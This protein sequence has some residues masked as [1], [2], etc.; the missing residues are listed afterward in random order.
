[1][2]Q[3]KFF[4]CVL[5]CT[6]LSASVVA[7]GLKAFKL[8]NGLS[9]FV[10]EDE[11]A[12]D[13]FG[14]V[15]VNVGA[16][17]DPEEYTGLAHYLEHMLFKGT[18][19]I[20]TLDWEKE[21]PIYVQIVAKYDELAQAVDP[22]QREAI[23]KEI[24]K[25]TIAAAQHNLSSDFSYL[26]QGIGGEN[27]NAGTSY[28]YTVYYNSFP[29]GGIYK[30][31]ELNSERLINPVFR[32]FQPELETVYEEYNR[33]Q[34]QPNSRESEFILS[35]IFPGHPY[36]RSVIGLPEHLKN[37]QLSRLDEFYRRWYVP[38]NMALILV[39][40]VKT[41]EVLP[42]IKEKFGRLESRPVPERKQYPE[43]PLKGRKEA[44]AKLSLYPQ[45][46]LAFPG[47]TTGSDEEIALKI[48][49]SILSNS[50]QTGLIDKLALDGDLLGGGAEALSFKERGSIIV[51]AIPF[52][53]LNQ[54]RFESLKATEKILLKEIKKLQ[55]GQFEEWLV[56]SIKSEMIRAF[57]LQ[58]ESRYNVATQLAEIFFAG[59]SVEDFLNYK[60]IVAT[61]S[62]EE[63]REAA[64][65]YFGSSYYALF[66]NEGKPPKGKELEKPKYDPIQP[67]RGAESEYAKAF[68]SQPVKQA[69]NAFASMEDVVIM[70][71]N[72]R[73]KLF[74]TPNPENDIFTLTLKFGIGSEKKPKLEMAAQLMNN[75]GIMGQM[76]AQAVKQAFSN[77]GAT[78]RYRV[79]DS[80]LYVTMS[81][82]EVNLEAS[83]NLLTRQILL[84]Q[85]DEKQ[86]NSLKG[87]YIQ[88]RAVEKTSNE[89]LGDALHE[90][91]LYRDKSKY[92]DRLSLDEIGELTVSNLTGEF[93]RATD[94][95]A[96]IHY[97]GMLP[98]GE[99][100]DILSKNLPL[101]QGEKASTSPEVRARVSYTENTVFFLPNSEA[102]Q[103]V[104]Y[105]YVNGS[106]YTKEKDP[107]RDAFNEYFSGGFNGLVMQEIR[108]YRS[109]AYSAGGSYIS[110]RVEGKEAAF[111][112]TL[113]TQ[114]DKTLDAVEVYVDLLA[115]M[116]QYPDRMLNIKT[117][118][119][120]TATV[121]K[122][123]FR[124]A[125]QLYE[126]WKLK[127]YA[128]SPAKTNQAA[129]DSLT[130]E[131]IVAFYSENIK[132]RPLVIAIAGNPKAIDEKALAK[133]GKV[134]TLSTS[135]VFGSK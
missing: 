76:D 47:I 39:G 113:G 130:F 96:Q 36:A 51:Y 91:L 16:K 28:D 34:D 68:R 90:Y 27:L 127:G 38:G 135:K 134:V 133:Y 122:P 17:E 41:T 98:V 62:T 77:L 79:D 100:Y 49:T 88:Q 120:E 95:E 106:S 12:P 8:P 105:F 107:Y 13:V 66:L 65:K 18:E 32:S 92:I 93:Q 53:D 71:I 70:P 60:E 99:V 104:V 103:S 132:G 15:A 112:G 4:T 89:I 3:L 83:C 131:D 6:L 44:N 114:A 20:G 30:W 82:F 21:K 54:R 33:G 85:L 7:Q 61:I 81:G 58:M 74:Y 52:F 50:S 26:T 9:V 69:G 72:D 14:M 67:V 11:T 86:M 19:K 102:K 80:Y 37:P 1:M 119:K 55:E 128:Q 109:M 123:H 10:W 116:P 94:Y 108:E 63:I 78:C 84:P 111:I 101:K 56:Q 87:S 118:L 48:C 129:V 23:S 35:A 73:S 64:K 2:K 75:A 59:K 43:T 25:L 115:N 42:V 24:N 31:L 110:P 45:T 97:V 46:L 124:D 126:Q 117:F 22:Q 5:V 40:N 29:P 125:S 121:E 57:D